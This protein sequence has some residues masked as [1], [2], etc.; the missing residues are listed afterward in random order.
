MAVLG[1]VSAE[2]RRFDVR[3]FGFLLVQIDRRTVCGAAAAVGCTF[4]ASV[5][6]ARSKH[7]LFF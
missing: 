7:L 5:D 2:R 4:L 3:I 1:V 6:G